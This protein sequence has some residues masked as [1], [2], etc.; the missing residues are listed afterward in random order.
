MAEIFG[1][2]PRSDRNEVVIDA[3]DGRVI[4]LFALSSGQQ[5]LLPLW[6][7]LDHF[8]SNSEYQDISQGT[9][10]LYIE[11]PEAHLFPEAQ[12][13][14]LSILASLLNKRE[15]HS[16]MVLTTHSPY[17]LAKANNLLLAGRLGYRK[18][19][20]RQK[21][22]ENFVPKSRWLLPS[23]VAC[24]GLSNGTAIDIVGKDGLISSEY[25][26]EVSQI[27]IDEHQA[28]YDAAV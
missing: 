20:I 18:R 3:P 7:G 21:R 14:V 24:Y 10:F 5:E 13:D 28:L 9:N 15:G 26:D 27:I 19:I 6:M 2:R 8:D 23:D 25:I 22:I 4:P 17:I 11:E 16:Q 12:A 1:G